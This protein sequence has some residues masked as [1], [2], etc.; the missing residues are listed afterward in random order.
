MTVAHLF[1]P[2]AS[3]ADIKGKSYDGQLSFECER[4]G[5]PDAATRLYIWETNRPEDRKLAFTTKSPIAAVSLSPNAEWIA[6]TI[7]LARP[8][9]DITLLRRTSLLEYAQVEHT[10]DGRLVRRITLQAYS[11]QGNEAA[12]SS[13]QVTIKRADLEVTGWS[14][15]STKA[16][17]SLIAEMNHA[18]GQTSQVDRVFWRGELIVPNLKFVSDAA[19]R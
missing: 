4:S 11:E 12:A 3:P 18:F 15:D 5:E 2:L 8:G 9:K 7:P 19:R 1:A 10:G 16:S 6:L 14:A 13:Y 17:V